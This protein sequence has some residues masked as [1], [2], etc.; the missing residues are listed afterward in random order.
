[1]YVDLAHLTLYLAFDQKWLRE[2]SFLPLGIIRFIFLLC[3]PVSVLCPYICNTINARTGQVTARYSS[4][5]RSQL[6]SSVH[7]YGRAVCGF[8]WCTVMAVK[9][10]TQRMKILGI[11]N[12][13]N[14][15]I[16]FVL[17]SN[18]SEDK[19]M[20]WNC[21]MTQISLDFPRVN[22]MALYHTMSSTV[23]CCSFFWGTSYLTW[24]SDT[25]YNPKFL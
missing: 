9:M 3:F 11:L 19:K 12:G 4:C 24:I 21:Q 20:F 10:N 25:F 17:Q 14:S 23:Q 13:K 5:V 2:E 15:N 7:F 8:H 6:I 1:M 16:D 18:P 22:T